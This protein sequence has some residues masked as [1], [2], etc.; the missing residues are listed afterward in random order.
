MLA[1]R[2]KLTFHRQTKE[3][4]A[5]L[6]VV[7]KGGI[8]F[9]ESQLAEGEPDVKPDKGRL[10]VEI[11]GMSA[12]L[13]VE[14]LSNVLHAPVINNTGLDGRY[15][16]KVDIGKYI[17]DAPKEGSTGGAP[18]DPAALIITGL[19]QELGLKLESKKMPL[20]LLIVDHVERVPI[21][22]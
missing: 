11:K 17:A 14:T 22:N 6:L 5:Y 4:P 3:L 20:D 19:E 21:E 1:E 16:A 13:F 7:A 10:S 2:F 12:S 18:F 15:D 8:K 9:N